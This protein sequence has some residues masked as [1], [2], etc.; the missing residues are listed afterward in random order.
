M[1]A[2][3]ERRAGRIIAGMGCGAVVRAW[4]P[5]ATMVA[6]AAA[7]L[8]VGAPSVT[9]AQAPGPALDEATV[10]AALAP[11]VED[12]S[13]GDEGGYSGARVGVCVRESPTAWRCSI[14]SVVV[15]YNSRLAWLPSRSPAFSHFETQC[16]AG[17]AR[18][19]RDT[20]GS[21]RTQ[22]NL[23]LGDEPPEQMGPA[24]PLINVSVAR[25]RQPLRRAV[26]FS[27]TAT[28]NEFARLP[29]GDVTVSATAYLFLG[30]STRPVWRTARRLDLP[31]DGV[32]RRSR[33]ALPTGL[34]RR[35]LR[36]RRQVR[37]VL[38]FKA[39]YPLGDTRGYFRGAHAIT[40][41]RP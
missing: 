21:L 35:A 36:Q 17:R 8:A 4:P 3:R 13:E 15:G 29:V 5:S 18:V 25:L 24:C 1:A 40:V 41:A 32:L 2:G 9:R 22:T 27:M 19:W 34:T 30:R 10:R 14:D 33:V 26:T 12:H 20:D 23:P 7:A 39:S 38:R 6:V 31:Q 37:A 11:M 28:A 16:P